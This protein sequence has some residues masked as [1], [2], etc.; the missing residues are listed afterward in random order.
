MAAVV[1]DDAPR[2]KSSASRTWLRGAFLAFLALY[3]AARVRNPEHWDPL[4][5]L[6]LAVHEAGHLVFSGFGE[7]MT[8]LGGSLFQVLVPVVFVGYFLR[9]RQRYAAAATLSW[10]GVNLLNVSR[11]IG[12]AR[13]QELPLL[14]GENTI[15]DWWYLLINWDLLPR[16]LAIARWVHFFGVVAF[17]AS[18]VGGVWT[19]KHGPAKPVITENK[20]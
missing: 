3:A 2:D 4:D 1:L 19:L 16:D 10:V 15:H 11:Y 17:L 5:D 12:D 18:V 14:G 6:N 9:T 13:A 20:R 7:T 8:I